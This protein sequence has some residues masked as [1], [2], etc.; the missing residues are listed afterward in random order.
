MVAKAK[1]RQRRRSGC[2]EMPDANGGKAK[3]ICKDNSLAEVFLKKRFATRAVRTNIVSD[4]GAV[5]EVDPTA[6]ER[7]YVAQ[8]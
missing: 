4:S 7:A 8:D 3:F 5:Q 6:L 2:V 1:R